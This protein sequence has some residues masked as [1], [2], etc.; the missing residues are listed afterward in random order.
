MRRVW[1]RSKRARLVPPLCSATSGCS[2]VRDSMRL[3]TPWL[4]IAVY[5]LHDRCRFV[6]PCASR[7][8]GL[9]LDVAKR[10]VIAAWMLHG[11]RFVRSRSRKP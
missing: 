9:D 4:Q 11:L 2:C 5:G 7:D 8:A 6:L 1:L 3:L 10:I